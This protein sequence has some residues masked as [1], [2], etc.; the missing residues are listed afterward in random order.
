[1]VPSSNAQVLGYGSS[2]SSNDTSSPRR[3]SSRMIHVRQPAAQPIHVV[4]RYPDCWDSSCCFLASRS[5]VILPAA[6]S[7]FVDFLPGGS[8][9][10]G[11]PYVAYS[12]ICP[13]RPSTTSCPELSAFAMTLALSID[14]CHA[15]REPVLRSCI[16][17]GVGSQVALC[18][19]FCT[20]VR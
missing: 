12:L 15:D 8:W 1:M 14:D 19:C 13:L 9:I 20:P 18:V 5:R 10:G 17:P 7:I 2:T 4:L 3:S 16:G 6:F 11:M